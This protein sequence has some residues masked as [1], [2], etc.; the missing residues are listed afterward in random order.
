MGQIELGGRLH[1]PFAKQIPRQLPVVPPTYLLGDKH[2]ARLQDSIDLLG[3]KR[4]MTVKDQIEKVILK[5]QL[6]ILLHLRH[7]NPISRQLGKAQLIVGRVRFRRIG[8]AGW[9]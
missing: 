2:S 5:R 4:F 3:R 6:V 7:F 8:A 1:C 9:R